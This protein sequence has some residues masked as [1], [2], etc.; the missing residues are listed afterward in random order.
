MIGESSP[1]VAKLSAPAKKVQQQAAASPLTGRRERDERPAGLEQVGFEASLEADQ[2]QDGVE[3]ETLFCGAA[4]DHERSSRRLPD[5]DPVV[6]SREQPG[7]RARWYRP[8]RQSRR[9]YSMLTFQI[10]SWEISDC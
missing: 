5:D 2:L 3:L 1:D 4:G 9:H 8:V 7:G 6:G 10:F